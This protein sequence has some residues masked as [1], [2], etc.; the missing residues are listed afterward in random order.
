MTTALLPAPS[1][2]NLKKQKPTAVNCTTDSFL[3][4]INNL[5][6]HVMIHY[7]FKTAIRYNFQTV[8]SNS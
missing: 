8:S 3:V 2:K 6:E 7:I 4:N 5:R 1:P